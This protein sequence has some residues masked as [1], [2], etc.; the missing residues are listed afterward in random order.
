MKKRGLFVEMIARVFDKVFKYFC[1][2]RYAYSSSEI[3][4]GRKFAVHVCMH[5]R[6]KKYVNYCGFVERE[7]ILT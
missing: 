2:H 4:G 5:C 7:N 3:I 6:K 1:L